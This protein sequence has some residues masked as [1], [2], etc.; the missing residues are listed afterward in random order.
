MDENSLDHTLLSEYVK[1]CKNTKNRQ[2]ELN[3]EMNLLIKK[4]YSQNQNSKFSILNS[5]L[6]KYSNVLTQPDDNVYTKSLKSLNYVDIER[7]KKEINEQLESI[8]N[9]NS[10]EYKSNYI[11]LKLLSNAKS[12]LGYCAKLFDCLKQNSQDKFDI[13]KII[14][15]NDKNKKEYNPEI[16]APMYCI[17]LMG[18]S[19]FIEFEL[20]QKAKKDH[21]LRVKRVD[22]LNNLLNHHEKFKE[23]YENKQ[24]N[25]KL[26]NKS[27]LYYFE[28]SDLERKRLEERRNKER[29]NRLMMEDEEGYRKLIDEKKDQ[30]LHFLLNQ[31]DQFIQNISNLVKQHKDQLN[32]SNSNEDGLNQ[33]DYYNIAHS[34]TEKITAQPDIMVGG[35]LKHYQLKGLEWMVSLYNNKLNGIL[36][37]E[38]G[39]GKTIQTISL[40]SYLY[41]VKNDMGPYLV[42]VPLS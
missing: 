12:H 29:L 35:K 9:K 39:L 38:M 34:I 5:F 2:I 37:D 30:R 6:S 32:I 15:G 31:T 8:K 4:Y 3:D 7:Q 41:G 27:I 42:I 17:N 23:F 16:K 19:D 10:E 18:A 24:N 22:F 28:R 36:A 25:L 26:L 1:K 20:N 11:K 21:I 14:S 40:I 13:K 33:S